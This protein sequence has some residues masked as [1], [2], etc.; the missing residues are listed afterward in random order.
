MK[1]FE[2]LTNENFLLYAAKNYYNPVCID[3]E[4]FFEDIKR[5]KYIKRL[6]NRYHEGGTLSLNLLLNHIVVVINVFD[7]EAGLRLL[8]FKL[9]NKYW[10]VIKPC[11]IFLK[12]VKN[13]KY[14]GIEMDQF[15]IDQ[16]RK[17]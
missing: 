6:I 10:S 11:L 9:E 13:D 8:E 5:F 1:L 7:V 14:V 2:E 4:E 16:L 15:V 12:V 17:I 3:A